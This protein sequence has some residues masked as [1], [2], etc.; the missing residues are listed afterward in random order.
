[1]EARRIDFNGWLRLCATTLGVGGV[2]IIAEQMPKRTKR[3]W[4]ET[5][6]RCT[7][8]QLSIVSLSPGNN[9][10]KPAT[11]H[12]RAEVASV[13]RWIDAAFVLG[14]PCV[15]I[16]AGWPPQGQ[17]QALWP[18]MVACIRQVAARAAQA[19]I[20]LVVEPHNHGGFLATS[21][22][23]LRLIKELDTPWVRINL[24]VGNY[25]QPD[26][27]AGIEASLLYAPHVVA[28]IH[29]LSPSGDELEFDY[30]RI[31][32][33]LK[34][35]RYRGFVTVEYEGATD[36]LTSVPKAVAML[37]RYARKYDL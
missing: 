30:D 15:R 29:R 7:D 37:R 10:G 31:F 23:T 35:H 36:E 28:K 24:D 16:F 22:Q 4:L 33:M 12:R 20:T 1:M 5:K 32:A 8:W 21:Q 3:F 13:Q 2:D 26:P 19:G 14:A 9:F 34:R 25:L 6:K 11:S 27:Y 18:K 17:A